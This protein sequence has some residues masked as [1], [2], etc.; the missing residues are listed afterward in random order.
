MILMSE[1]ETETYFFKNGFTFIVK[2]LNTV[3]A[4]NLDSF[5]CHFR[6]KEVPVIIFP[7]ET[8]N[9]IASEMLV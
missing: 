9:A 8:I 2:I 1:F 5:S 3:D 6:R 4:L 7:D